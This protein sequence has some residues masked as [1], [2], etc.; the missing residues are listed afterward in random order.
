MKTLNILALS[1]LVFLAACSGFT[2]KVT[3]IDT[4]D[5]FPQPTLPDAI[6]TQE[7]QVMVLN[8]AQLQALLN[9]LK[10]NPNPNFAIIGVTPDDYN[11][12]ISNLE[13]LQRYILQEQQVIKT[14]M[15]YFQSKN[16]NATAAP[17]PDILAP[18]PV[19]K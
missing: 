1:G 8:Q 4:A 19:T 7:I 12:I 2:T 5:D 14:Y 18:A 16:P 6:Q 10:K 9:N 17:T 15:L 3:T 13:E 11:K